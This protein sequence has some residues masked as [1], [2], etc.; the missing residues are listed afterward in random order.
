MCKAYQN[1]K[2]QRSTVPP[3][4]NKR[5]GGAPCKPDI[6]RA[7]AYPLLLSPLASSFTMLLSSSH[8][9]RLVQPLSTTGG[10]DYGCR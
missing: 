1:Q 7:S 3:D 6:L 10:G 9:V 4:Q 8:I 2:T 5:W